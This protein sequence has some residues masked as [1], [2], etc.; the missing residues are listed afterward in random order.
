MLVLGGLNLFIAQGFDDEDA[1][2]ISHLPAWGDWVA[3]LLLIVPVAWRRVAPAWVC[4]WVGLGFVAF[5]LLQVPEGLMSSVAVYL[6][7]HAAG[8]YE[9]DKGRRDLARG[10]ALAGGLV[11]VVVALVQEAQAVDFDAALALTFTIGINVAFYV[12]A[13]ALGDST[14]KRAEAELELTRRAEQLATEREARAQQ[15]VTEERVRIARELHDVVAHHV[16]VMGVQAAA[17]RHVMAR[18]AEAATGALANV[19]E[20]GRQ[21]VAE[22]QRLVG[23]LRSEHAGGVDEPQPTLDG[24]DA[25]VGSMRG[26]GLGVDLRVIG[27]E[28][29]VPSSVELSAYRIIQEALTNV[30]RHAPG[31]ATT[32]VL[33]YL[34][35]ALQVEVVNGTPTSHGEATGPGGG[36]GLLGMR[37]RVAMLGGTF[38]HGPAPRGGYRVAALLPIAPV[39]APEPAARA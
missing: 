18:D 16:S 32:V 4:A 12:T 6:T 31:A 11:A 3:F 38:D 23:I 26:A 25:L 15:A 34:S 17:A 35:E 2:F 37:E 9:A 5:R 14:R 7:I 1:M 36:R 30:L 28:R 13:W 29:P 22:L 27:R 10:L 19:E 24:L 39:P 33:S 8:A 20:S 21:A